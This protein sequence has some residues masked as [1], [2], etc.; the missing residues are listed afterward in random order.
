MAWIG[1]AQGDEILIEGIPYRCPQFDDFQ[2]NFTNYPSLLHAQHL[3]S[4]LV[5]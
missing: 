4:Y 5:K 3:L 1:H 2:F